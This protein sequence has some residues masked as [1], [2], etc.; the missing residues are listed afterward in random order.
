MQNHMDYK[1]DVLII[2]TG[3]AGLYCALNLR[4]DFQILMITKESMR[5][6][7]TYLAQGGISTAL[8]KEDIP[9]FIKDTLKAGGYK[10]N[11]SSVQILCTESREN[12]NTLLDWGLPLDKKQGGLAYTREGAHS[13]N[14]IVHCSDST[15]KTLEECLIKK[16]Q[17]HKNITIFENTE[18]VDILVE[19][20]CCIGGIV[21]KEGKPF[22][23]IAKVVVLAC[24]GIGGL[25]K[26]TTNQSTVTGDGI[27]IAIKNNIKLKD[28]SYIQFH[29]TALYEENINSR[30]FL[31]SESLRGEGAKL[32]NSKGQRFVKEL[33]PRNVVAKAIYKEIRTSGIPYV[34][35]DFSFQPEDYIKQRFP[36]IYEECKKRGLDITKEA[37]P[38]SPAQHYFMGGIEVDLFSRTSMNNL[39]AV[40][41]TACTG[42]HGNNRLASNSLL[43]GIVFSK[44]AASD[45]NTQVDLIKAS[46]LK[47]FPDIL[48]DLKEIQ[49]N[50]KNLVIK[51][52]LRRS[53]E[54]HAEFFNH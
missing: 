37:I 52:L 13:I 11:I 48:H 16:V 49:K 50:M 31:I 10:N 24:G 6:S 39:Y 17:S 53:K 28:L 36:L 51:E 42:V 35:L 12:I 43:E 19:D 9:C 20:N 38:V 34:M 30:R 2:G 4:E 15:G 47:D 27:A 1:T 25:F 46:C 5:D 26:N 14:R 8:N 22:I 3:V 45:I 44:R 40:G 29:P 18:F 21:I 7:N 41:E 23:I 32:Y 33:L 54:F